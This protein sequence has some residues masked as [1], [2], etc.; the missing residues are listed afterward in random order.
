MVRKSDEFI[1]VMPQGHKKQK[2]TN[3][4]WATASTVGVIVPEN[5]PVVGFGSRPPP[6]VSFSRECFSLM[7]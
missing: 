4:F 3:L 2:V 6:N 7:L 1:M 5:A